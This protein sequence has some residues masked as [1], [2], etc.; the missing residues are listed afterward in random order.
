[1]KNLYIVLFI[2]ISNTIWASNNTLSK[3][4]SGKINDKETGEPITGAYIYL[5][6]LKTGAISDNKGN[7]KIENLPQVKVLV[8]VSFVGYKNI[9]EQV[10]LTTTTNK[11]FALEHSITEMNEI[12]VTGASKAAELKRTPT[13]IS[14]V[15]KS[16]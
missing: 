3:T 1:M 8:Q 4:L 16:I 15:P 14:V 13:P 10:D 12:V 11:D 9:F 6:D 2:I 7:Y 5:P